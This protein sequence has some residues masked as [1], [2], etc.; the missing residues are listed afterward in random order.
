M[1]SQTRTKH[2]TSLSYRKSYL[3]HRERGR[4][5]RPIWGRRDWD[6][7]TSV[8]GVGASGLLNSSLCEKERHDFS[9]GGQEGAG[10]QAGGLNAKG[11]QNR[12]EAKERAEQ[13]RPNRTRGPVRARYRQG[14]ERAQDSHAN[15]REMA[16]SNCNP[17]SKRGLQKVAQ[18]D[19]RTV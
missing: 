2:S 9:A 16:R 6:S 14:T 4:P 1:M 3:L 10:R 12:D 19:G 5:W 13:L 15:R 18:T 8:K 11:I 7:N 17:R